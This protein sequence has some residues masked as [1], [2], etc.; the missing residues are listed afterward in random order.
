MEEQLLAERCTATH[1]AIRDGRT[2]H[3]PYGYI[4]KSTRTKLYLCPHCG[5]SIEEETKE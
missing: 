4:D 3:P 5:I 2:N 1:D